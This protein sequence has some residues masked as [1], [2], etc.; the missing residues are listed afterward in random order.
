MMETFQNK[1]GVQV[2]HAWGMTEMSPL[3]T[4]NTPKMKHHSLSEV[5]KMDLQQSAGRV[6]FGVDMKIVDE[7]GKTLPNDGKSTGELKVTGPWIISDY[8]NLDEKAEAHAEEGWFSTGDVCAIDPDGYIWIT[9]R[10]KDVIKSG[11]EWISSI[12][13]E[14]IA[15]GHPK[16]AEAAAIGMPHPKWD[17]RPLLVV[18]RTQAGQDLDKNEMLSFLEGKIAKWWTPDDIVFVDELPHTATGKLSKLQLRERFKDYVLPTA[19]EGGQ[20]N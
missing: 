2:L 1:Y 8:F 4:L 9:D 13:L 7:D 5:E 19:V 12:D 17:E 14:N 3:G 11:G 16:V 10:L 15:V 6:L 20:S 18:V